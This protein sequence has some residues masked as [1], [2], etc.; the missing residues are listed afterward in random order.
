MSEPSLA[1]VSRTRNSS[2]SLSLSKTTG[3]KIAG[4]TKK[5]HVFP[6]QTSRDGLDEIVNPLI[7][8]LK[9]YLEFVWLE[10]FIIIIFFFSCCQ[11]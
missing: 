5:N 1:S 10:N 2:L 7:Y 4:I 9:R 8:N 11:F 3:E 6:K